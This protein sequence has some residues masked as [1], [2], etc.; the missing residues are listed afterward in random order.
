MPA[1]FRGQLLLHSL[2]DGTRRFHTS[3]AEA[4]RETQR[5][6]RSTPPTHTLILHA[7]PCASGDGTGDNFPVVPF[8][9]A[10]VMLGLGLCCVCQLQPLSPSCC[11]H[12]RLVGT[13]RVGSLLGEKHM[14][15]RPTTPDPQVLGTQHAVLPHDM[16]KTVGRVLGL[17][18]HALR[19]AGHARPCASLFVSGY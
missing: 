14:P 15:A 6:P 11:L 18:L 9:P 13:G 12:A 17:R 5:W 4:Q 16:N 10:A 19:N 7:V 2:H 1:Y 8:P 3:Q